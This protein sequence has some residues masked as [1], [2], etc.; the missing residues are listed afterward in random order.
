MTHRSAPTNSNRPV[1][2]ANV[3]RGDD[4]PTQLKY[5][6]TVHNRLCIST[7]FNILTCW[8]CRT[9]TSSRGVP[10]SFREGMMCMRER[11][12]LSLC[13]SRTTRPAFAN[14]VAWPAQPF[15]TGCTST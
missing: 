1:S 9:Y 5:E 10:V 6:F 7:F 11:A 2:D 12:C 8:L 4:F 13:V 3:D 15:F 14:H